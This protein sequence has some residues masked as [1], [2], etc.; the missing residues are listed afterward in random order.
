MDPFERKSVFVGSSTTDGA[1][2]GLFARRSFRP[3]DLVSYFS[4][5]RALQDWILPDNLTEAETAEAAAYYFN[6]YEYCVEWW[7]CPEDV[8]M[9]IP[10]QFRSVIAFRRTLGHKAN[11]RFED[12]NVFFETLL[13]PALGPISCLIAWREIRAGEEI[14]SDYM[15]NL[16][17]AADWYRDQYYQ[18]YHTYEDNLER[19]DLGLYRRQLDPENDD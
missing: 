4:G 7:N 13:H 15:Y 5:Q 14:F 2:E 16:T 17:D 9:D 6:L 18:V 1:N 8:M 12:N 10:L 19:G 3:G 11:H